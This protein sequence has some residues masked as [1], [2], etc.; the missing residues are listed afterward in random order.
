MNGTIGQM[1]TLTADIAE[2]LL[3]IKDADSGITP[4][5]VD[6]IEQLYHLSQLPVAPAPAAEEPALPAVLSPH[7][8][9]QC[10]SIAETLRQDSPEHES[11]LN[12]MEEEPIQEMPETAEAEKEEDAEPVSIT[13]EPEPE[14]EPELHQLPE[15]A[16]VPEQTP[17]PTLE[18]E[19]E[20]NPEPPCQEDEEKTERLQSAARSLS[21]ATLR[22]AMSL[23]DLFLYRRTLFG[24]SAAAFND[25]LTEIA[26]FSHISE[27]RHFMR[28]TLHINMK[29]TE[30]KDF[31]NLMAPFFSEF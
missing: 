4:E 22:E 15:Q 8:E 3:A 2:T 20:A 19:Q 25:A 23:N 31:I 26:T 28:D 21:P 5:L 14:T 30:A 1:L 18:P 7:E 6:K 29:T 17:E 27:V 24:G 12:A 13:S 10:E 11:I 16:S 9:I